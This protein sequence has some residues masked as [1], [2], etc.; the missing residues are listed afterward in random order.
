MQ[1]D[2]TPSV[3][4]LPEYA[5]QDN[6]ESSDDLGEND[7]RNDANKYNAQDNNTAAENQKLKRKKRRHHTEGGIETSSHRHRRHREHYE[8]ASSRPS[9]DLGETTQLDGFDD[10]GDKESERGKDP[11]ADVLED[12]LNG[13]GTMAKLFHKVTGDLVGVS[14]A[15]R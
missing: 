15:K 2:S 8:R 14:S 13:R 1:F 11:V 12:I 9:D 4:V 3:H 7:S 5:V 10:K 6:G